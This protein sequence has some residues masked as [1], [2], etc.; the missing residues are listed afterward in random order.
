MLKRLNACPT[1]VTITGV[2]V[3]LHNPF[4]ISEGKLNTVPLD[5]NVNLL[6]KKLQDVIGT[7]LWKLNTWG[8]LRA[9]GGGPQI[10]YA[11]QTLSVVQ[12]DTVVVRQPHF[13]FRNVQYSLDMRGIACSD[14]NYVCVR[15]R[16]G[17]NPSP[18]FTFRGKPK[19]SAT[20][21]DCTPL[22]DCTGELSNKLL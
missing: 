11:D 10:S 17:D 19:Q 4:P 2:D 5:V 7:G 15:I 3:A 13:F 9:D 18:D 6:Q 8:S 20:F 14:I 12:Q 22:V 21:Q 1:A 16:K